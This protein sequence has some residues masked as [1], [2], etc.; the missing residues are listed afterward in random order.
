M[1]EAL[2]SVG[3]FGPFGVDAYRWTGG[4]VACCDVNARYTMGWSV[5]MSSR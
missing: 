5:G 4:F 1:A 2:R 3:Y